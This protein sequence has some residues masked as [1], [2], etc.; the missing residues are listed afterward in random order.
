MRR[1]S[2][3]VL[4][5]AVAAGAEAQTVERHGYWNVQQHEVRSSVNRLRYRLFVSLPPAYSAKDTTTHPV[6]YVLDGN[7]A[8]P[9]IQAARRY[10]GEG[11]A[12]P[13]VIIV[14]IGYPDGDDAMTRRTLDLTP[15]PG[16]DATSR[17]PSGGAPAFLETIRRDVVPLIERTY[18]TRSDRALLGHSYGGLFALYALHTAPELFERYGI[19]SPATWWDDRR[20]LREL[21]NAGQLRAPSAARVFVAVG[22]DEDPGMRAEADSVS[23]VLARAYGTR[24]TLASRRF[25]GNHQSYF[26][27]AVSPGLVFLYPAPE[28]LESLTS[29]D[30]RLFAVLSGPERVEVERF[31]RN[32]ADVRGRAF[33][34]GGACF[35]YELTLEPDGRVASARLEQSL[36]L[37][38]TARAD[39]RA[40]RVELR[41]TEPA[42]ERSFDIV[43]PT[44]L[45]VPA[46]IASLDQVVR[47]APA[48]A[49]DSTR[50]L[51]AN[52]RHA[53]TTTGVISRISADSI[54]VSHPNVELR[55]HVSDRLEILGGTTT[56][57]GSPRAATRWVV[58]ERRPP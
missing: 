19:F 28:C 6:L 5:L 7:D 29:T 18:R 31:V 16:R 39:L 3:A 44:A 41:T 40:S 27:E 22:A 52:F 49:G 10:L 21:A 36:G 26:P 46:F 38:R 43:G 47:M 30:G 56:P 17:L 8:F 11:G 14:G 33:Q 24:L 34:A 23:A 37:P 12:I 54:R 13:Q 1:S 57:G 9:L 53:D 51:L 45:F 25:A 50:V 55:V 58:V 35:R 4:S 48:R 32:G 42:R 2:L 15:T 20:L